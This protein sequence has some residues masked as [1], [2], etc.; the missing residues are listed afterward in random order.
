M[1]AP[2]CTAHGLRKAGA[3]IA[4]YNG[5]T[6][7]QLMSIFGWKTLKEAERYTKAADQKRIAATAMP[8]LLPGRTGNESGEPLEEK[9]LTSLISLTKYEGWRP[10]GESTISAK[11]T[12][13][14]W[15]TATKPT[16]I[17]K[18]LFEHWQTTRPAGGKYRPAAIR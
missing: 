2:N 5:A 11:A 4:A 17:C 10:A 9:W 8:L 1:T 16:M 6:L 3:V 14:K 18:R 13:Y 12:T 15:Q 7:H